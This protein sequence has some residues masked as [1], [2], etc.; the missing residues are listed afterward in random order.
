M[1]ST[2]DDSALCYKNITNL[3]ELLSATFNLSMISIKNS[4]Y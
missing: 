2:L 1:E 3:L 4:C